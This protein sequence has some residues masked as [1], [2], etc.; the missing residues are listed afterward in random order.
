[1]QRFARVIALLVPTLA[2]CSFILDFD[3]LTGG[4]A[5]AG[6]GGAAGAA[7]GGKAGTSG[8]KGGK[9]GAGGTGGGGTSGGA[10][11]GGEPTGQGG[12]GGS[13]DC[14]AVCF[15]DDPCTV[16]GCT[17][18]GACID[19]TM[20]GLLLDG[21]DERIAADAH[22]R[23][24][25]TAA[26]DAFF[27]SSFSTVAGLPEVTFYRLDGVDTEGALVEIGKLGDL[28]LGAL[29]AAEPVSAAGLAFEPGLGLIHG[30]AGI[31]DV[32]GGGG[33]RVWHVAL[34]MNFMP[35]MRTPI[36][37]SY[38]SASPY[39]FPAAINLRGDIYAAWIAEDR[40]ITVASPILAAPLPLAAGRTAS[41]VTLIGTARGNPVAL[42]TE[43]PGGVT[44]ESPDIPALDI[45][46][47]QPA[48]G[49][50]SS[51]SATD[52]TIPGFWLAGWTKFAPASGGDE[53]YLTTDGRGIGCS[54]MGCVLD[55]QNCSANSTMNLVRNQAL[56]TSTRPGDRNGLVTFVQA[57][58]V[59]G[60][61]PGTNE[62]IGALA[63][64]ASRVDFG[65]VP[66]EEPPTITALGES[67]A[68]SETPA[69]PPDLR[70]PDWPVLGFVEP[71]RVALAFIEPAASGDELRVQRYRICYGN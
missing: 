58:P 47:C 41:T 45:P 4:E 28:G 33:A 49:L 18:T 21:V 37:P 9:G 17:S 51:I 59:L 20:A 67:I 24:T 50:Y 64:I 62:A 69:L 46:E 40:T 65:N 30:F 22:F 27:L 36:G 32:G 2:S 13:A 55:E 19:E 3:D 61:T 56:M 63:L 53:G 5:E 48:A 14:P 12:E 26:S 52:T 54:D 38:W 35:R 8:G 43:E 31:A 66:F 34:D 42:Y 6:R 70:G 25:M 29:G 71:D 39:N 60:V 11:E 16:D 57:L 15:D 7:M 23:V 1:M 44:L 68:V 10:G